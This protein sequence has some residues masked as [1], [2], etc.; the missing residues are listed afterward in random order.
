MGKSA[1]Q[2]A[3]LEK[4]SDGCWDTPSRFHCLFAVGGKHLYTNSSSSRVALKKV[5]TPAQYLLSYK[6]VG[7]EQQGVFS[8][9][10]P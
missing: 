3:H 10:L 4:R 2:S 9:C 5:N 1:A 8:L 6:G 7:I